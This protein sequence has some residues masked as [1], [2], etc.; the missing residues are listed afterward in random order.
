MKTHTH[1]H[2][3]IKSIWSKGSLLSKKLQT[4]SVPGGSAIENLPVGAGNTGGQ[5]SREDATYQ[6]G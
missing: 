1:T 5:L 4:G 2:T 6:S 3:T